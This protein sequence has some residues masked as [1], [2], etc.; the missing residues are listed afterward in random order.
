VSTGCYQCHGY[1]GG[2]SSQ[3]SRL[4]SPPAYA[5]FIAQL[6]KPVSVM[7]PY[8]PNVLSDAQVADIY[9]YVQSL[10]KP[11]NPESIQLLK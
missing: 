11:P 7:P 6:R 8:H 2:G 10:P 1:S 5:R 4:I 3:G 9:A